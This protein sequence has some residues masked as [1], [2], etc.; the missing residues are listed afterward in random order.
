MVALPHF[1][2]KFLSVG[3]CLAWA[4]EKAEPLLLR[5]SPQTRASVIMALLGLVV[6]GLALVGLALIGGRYVLRIARKSH[7]PTPSN[8]DAW[9]RNP[10]V[11]P[12]QTS[13]ADESD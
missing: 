6:V 5:L 8:E 4:N 2:A 13:Q 1:L 12:D 11:P 3:Q 9:Y 7:G 10:L